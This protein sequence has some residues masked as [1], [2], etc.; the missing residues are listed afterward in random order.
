MLSVLV[1]VCVF[2]LKRERNPSC[3]KQ[4]DSLTQQGT[5]SIPFCTTQDNLRFVLKTNSST[6]KKWKKNFNLNIC[7]LAL[8]VVKNTHYLFL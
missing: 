2:F 6:Q 5:R 7:W 4:V 3:A 8:T 1:F